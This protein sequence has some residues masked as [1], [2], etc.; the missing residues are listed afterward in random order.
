MACHTEP[1]YRLD[2]RHH[3]QWNACPLKDGTA[4]SMWSST[5]ADIGRCIVQRGT[6]GVESNAAFNAS[7][8]RTLF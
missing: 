4:C 2:A 8:N 3:A 7:E 1:A 5:Q 6:S